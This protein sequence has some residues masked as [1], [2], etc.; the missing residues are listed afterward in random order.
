VGSGIRWRHHVVVG[1]DEHYVDAMT[2]AD[3]TEVSIYFG[4]HW[5]YPTE[6]RLEESDLGDKSL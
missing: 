2:G 4:E 5:K 1:V 6:Y 3:G